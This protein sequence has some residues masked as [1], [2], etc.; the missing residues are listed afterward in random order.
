VSKKLYVG[1]LPFSSNED[2]VKS[3]FS[4]YGTVASAKIVTDRETGRSRGFCFVE[5]ESDEAAS[6]AISNLNGTDFNG[7]RLVVNE[8]VKRERSPRPQGQGY[9]PRKNG[10]RNQNRQR[11]YDSR[12]Y[13]KYSGNRNY[14]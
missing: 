3:L 10:P 7:R 14:R 4:N 11:D 13:G 5:M 2:D 9:T 8:A 12:N 6:S 1:N